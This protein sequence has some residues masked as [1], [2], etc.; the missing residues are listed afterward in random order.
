MDAAGFERAH[1]AGNSLGGWIG[2]ELG[3]R[4]RALSV[5]AISPA[6]LAWGREG[7]WGGAVLRAM[8]W[9]TRHAPVPAPLLRNVAGRTLLAGPQL[10]RPWRA[11]PDDLIEQTAMFAEAEGFEATL[12]HTLG[13]QARG[14]DQIRCPVLVLWGSQD[15]ILLPRQGPRFERLI[16]G[17][18][19]RVLKGLGHVPMSDDP[20]LLAE[21]IGEF[22]LGER[23]K[24]R[25]QFVRKPLRVREPSSRALDQQVLLRFPAVQALLARLIERLPPSSRVRQAVVWRGSR[26]GMEAFNRR[27]IDAALAFGHPEFEF[28]P[29][30]DFVEAGF[31]EPCYRGAAGFREY[32]S[33]WSEVFGSDLRIEPVE[34]IDMSD[35]VVLLAELPARAQASG[36]PFT[37]KIATVSVLEHGKA[38]RVQTY[39]DHAEALEAAGLPG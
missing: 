19:L 14:L 9:A 17:C 33:A 30:P 16:A 4:G 28:Q 25:T 23:A 37:G 34:L 1:V 5:T 21:A 32:V 12:A 6:G 18:E 38:I 8:R 39:L 36:V 15:V 10:S 2:L 22:A 7:A 3:R 24:P 20:Q 29:P 31:F 35:R 27:D 11:D 26:L 13:S